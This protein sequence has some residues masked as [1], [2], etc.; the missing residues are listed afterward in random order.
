MSRQ[1]SSDEIKKA[2]RKL[3]AELHPDK[4]QNNPAAEERFKRVNAAYHVLIDEKKRSLYDEFGEVSLREGFNA[5]AARAY[6]GGGRGGGSFEEMF[7]GAGQGGFADIL[8][9]LFSGGRARRRPRRMP[10]AESEITVD[11]VS[12]VR[13]AEL[14]LAVSGGRTVKVR[15]PPGATE[16]DKLRVK[17]AGPVGPGGAGDLLLTL[18]VLPH[19]HFER[20]GL[21][22]TLRLPITVGEAYLG[23]KIE[24]PTPTGPVQ[25][26]VPSGAQSGQRMRLRGKGVKR[27]ERQGD[28]Y[29][30]FLVRLPEE[31]SPALEEAAKILDEATSREFREELRF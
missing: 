11:F 19:P 12:A 23:A 20:E 25:L 28:L 24:V 31:R 2:Y 8:G 29:V 3:A 13:G 26:K 21:D 22:L 7:S 30:Q 10:D 9:D 15:I 1:A 4:N 5:D 18:Q 27:G 17:G 6:A 16:G 14:E